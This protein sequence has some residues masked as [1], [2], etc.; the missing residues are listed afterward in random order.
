M[1]QVLDRVK[2]SVLWI[3]KDHKP[4]FKRPLLSR[5]P[6]PISRFLGYR[7]SPSAPA[8]SAVYLTIFVSTFA[9]MLANIALA[10]R[11]PLFVNH[12]HFTTLVPSFAASCILIYN[13]VDA[14]LSQ[15]RPFIFG[16]ILA[17]II[18]IGIEKLF[19]LDENN[20]KYMWISGSLSVACSSIAMTFTGTTHPPAGATAL[21]PSLDS[22][23]RKLG[24]NFLPVLVIHTFVFMGIAL[25]INNIFRQYPKCWLF[26]N[27]PLPE[28]KISAKGVNC[29]PNVEL[30]DEELFVLQGI[31][32]KMQ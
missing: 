5:I 23:V 16:H 3:S 12:W 10:E 26:P 11:S 25:V 1:A 29:P 9:G 21:L 32:K 27:T 2:Q 17:G 22:E 13:A 4:V 14:P 31:Q 28:V 19:L 20:M 15:P 18:G 30:S 24:W 6:K 7:E 8:L